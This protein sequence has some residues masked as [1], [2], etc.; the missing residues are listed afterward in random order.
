MTINEMIK[1]LEAAGHQFSGTGDR[2][3]AINGGFAFTTEGNHAISPSLEPGGPLR[4]RWNECP[5]CALANDRIRHEMSIMGVED[6]G[7]LLY[8][9]VEW[10]DAAWYIHLPSALA[11]V[12]VDAAD[13]VTLGRSG[14]KSIHTA[15][16]GMNQ[17]ENA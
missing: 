6:D 15:L 17:N 4:N 13:G 14:H 5:V 16:K 2:V 7:G 11:A 8:S 9:G 1:N 3:N 10:K 12:V